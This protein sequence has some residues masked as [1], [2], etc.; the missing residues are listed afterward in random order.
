[1]SKY[2]IDDERIA[3]IAKAAYL[4]EAYV[5]SIADLKPIEPLSDKEIFAIVNGSKNVEG[6]LM[7]PFSFAREIEAHILGDKQ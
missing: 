5:R 4:S 7:L 3:A 6:D 2:I 1:M